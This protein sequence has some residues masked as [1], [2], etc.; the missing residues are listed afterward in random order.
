MLNCTPHD[1]VIY[2]EDKKTVIGTLKPGPYLIR[3]SQSDSTPHY[4]GIQL[5]EGDKRIVQVR[6]LARPRTNP[7][8]IV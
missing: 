8:V 3:L 6:R 2:A 1:V 7:A 5:F 4:G